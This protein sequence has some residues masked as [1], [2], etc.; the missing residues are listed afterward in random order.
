MLLLGEANY[1][2]IEYFLSS[3]FGKFI[4]L[5]LTGLLVFKY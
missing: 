4:V 5:G 2:S 1:S 3:I